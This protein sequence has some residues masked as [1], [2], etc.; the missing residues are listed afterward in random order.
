MPS[1]EDGNTGDS[2]PNFPRLSAHQHQ[3][4]T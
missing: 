4:T 3:M 1:A 2:Y